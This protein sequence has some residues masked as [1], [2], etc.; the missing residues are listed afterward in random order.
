M[1]PIF[2]VDAFTSTPFGGNPAGVCLLTEIA[3]ETWMQAVA[4]EMNVSETAFLNR[5]HNGFSIRF[6]T[7]RVE[8]SLCGHATLAS[9]HVLFE[10]GLAAT[11]EQISLVASGG[12]LSAQL[13]GGWIVLDFPACSIDDCE[14]PDLITEALNKNPTSCHRF[15]QWGYLVTM[16]DEATVRSL[17]PDF[18]TMVAADLGLVVATAPADDPDF[19]FV[20]RCFAPDVGIDED[21]VTGVAHCGLAPFWASRLGK[22]EMIGHQISER[23]GIVGVSVKGDRVELRGQAVTVLTGEIASPIRSVATC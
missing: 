19:D 2:Q 1:P 8:V 10:T 3:P 4:A 5:T 20:S 18:A 14:P 16:D 13:D 11:D 15:G 12:E 9:A 21:P 6:F 7:P 23:S 17:Q 22:N